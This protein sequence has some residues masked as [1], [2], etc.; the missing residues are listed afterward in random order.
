MARSDYRQ[1]LYLPPS[2]TLVSRAFDFSRKFVTILKMAEITK[3]SIEKLAEL[4]RLD[5]TT[6]E[7]EKFV[8]D[9]GNILSHFKELESLDTAGVKPMTGGTSARNVFREDAP[10]PDAFAGQKDIIAAF[11]EERAGYNKVPPVF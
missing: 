9:L 2:T 5:F 4:A 1:N 3:K 10:L 7:K 11:P 6:P 8:A